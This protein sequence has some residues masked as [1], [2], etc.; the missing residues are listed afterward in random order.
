MRR[1]GQSIPKNQVKICQ[2]CVNDNDPTMLQ[3]R[4][5]SSMGLELKKVDDIDVIG[6]PAADEM[7]TI[8]AH[9]ANSV[10]AKIP[11]DGRLFFAP[12]QF[13]ASIVISQKEPVTPLAPNDPRTVVVL[14]LTRFECVFTFSRHCRYYLCRQNEKPE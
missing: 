1:V 4:S 13:D 14:L 11:G 7:D 3:D 8:E 12:V 10:N 2:G 6:Y 5:L 9:A